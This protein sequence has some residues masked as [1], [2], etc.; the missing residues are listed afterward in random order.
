MLL[1]W[2]LIERVSSSLSSTLLLTSHWRGLS[3]VGN[4]VDDESIG[5]ERADEYS[6]E[7]IEAIVKASNIAQSV[8][9]VVADSLNVLIV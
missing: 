4:Q 3:C 6:D 2:R 8:P 5:C 1:I 9:V 7:Q